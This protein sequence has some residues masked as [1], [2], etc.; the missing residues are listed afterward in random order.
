[1]TASS[2]QTRPVKTD[3]SRSPSVG[4]EWV[5]DV[6]YALVAL[7]CGLIFGLSAP[8]LEQWYIAWF[9]LTPLLLLALRSAEPSQAAF[10]GFLFGI[11]YNLVYL[12]WATSVRDTVWTCSVSGYP[13][14]LKAIT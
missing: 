14:L 6:P 5:S 12:F 10:R 7:A 2:L 8:G 9:G 13:L 1:M 11:G 3:M 4:Q